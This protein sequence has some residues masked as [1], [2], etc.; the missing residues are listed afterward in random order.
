MGQLR[1]SK[2]SGDVPVTLVVQFWSSAMRVPLVIC[3]GAAAWT[4]GACVRIALQIVPG[5]RRH[6]AEAARARRPID[7]EPDST[8][9]MFVPIAAKTPRH[10]RLG[11]LADGHHRDDG[12][13][14]DDD[15][16]RRQEAARLVAPERRHG[17]GHDVGEVHAVTLPSPAVR[18]SCCVSETI[19]P[20]RT[21][22]IARRVA[23]H[24]GLVRHEDDGEPRRARAPGRAP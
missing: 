18:G 17:D 11:A 9:S 2:N 16:E 13:D 14:A 10:A 24:V 6:A 23:G 20:S 22:T 5:E 15:A 3:A 8:M 4:A 21:T 1:M 7:V 19:L 12:R